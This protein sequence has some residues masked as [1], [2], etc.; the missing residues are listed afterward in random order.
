MGFVRVT[1][2]VFG[3]QL[4][5]TV[6]VVYQPSGTPVVVG[7]AS[8]L[9]QWVLVRVRIVVTVVKPVEQTST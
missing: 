5:Q 9:A 2:V 8:Q 4:P 6:T 7:F 1:V 3:P